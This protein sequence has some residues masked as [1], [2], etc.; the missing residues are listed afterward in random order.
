MHAEAP[1]GST[2][3]VLIG[4]ITGDVVLRNR[5]AGI[6]S[7][8]S[9][10]TIG[11]RVVA[12]IVGAAQAF[13][14]PF[15]ACDPVLVDWLVASFHRRVAVPF[16]GIVI[17]PCVSAQISLV[18]TAH[19]A[20]TSI[21][22]LFLT[23]NNKIIVTEPLG[24]GSASFFSVFFSIEVIPGEEANVLISALDNVLLST[25]TLMTVLEDGFV[26]A[27]VLNLIGLVLVETLHALSAKVI[28]AHADV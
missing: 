6:I 15:R 24:N 18:F 28:P 22:L 23:S 8:P 5:S 16:V 3:L 4:E 25:F 7:A 12:K 1:L 17:E 21:H 26:E 27:L 14:L 11:P 2:D 10:L 20:K 19:K 9:R 13:V